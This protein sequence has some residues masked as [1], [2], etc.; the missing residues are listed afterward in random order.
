M[1][2]PTKKLSPGKLM[3]MKR[4]AGKKAQQ[5]T[6]NHITLSPRSEIKRDWVDGKGIYQR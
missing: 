3:A 4:C 2:K 6:K 5:N 1:S